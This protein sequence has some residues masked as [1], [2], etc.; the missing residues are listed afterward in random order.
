[1]KSL[2]SRLIGGLF[3][4]LGLAGLAVGATAYVIDRGAIDRSLDDELREIA[5][6]VDPFEAARVESGPATGEDIF[7]AVVWTGAGMV[8]PEGFARPTEIGLATVA[9]AGEDWRVYADIRADRTVIGAQRMEVRRE[10]VAA[11]A[12]QAV[13]PILL[14]IPVAWITIG[15]IVARAMRPLDR[16]AE[17]L[18]NLGGAAVSLSTAGVPAEV[19]PLVLAMNDLIARLQR[20][21][22]FR[23]QFVSDAAHE[24]RTPLAALQLQLDARHGDSATLRADAASSVAR[25]SALVNQMLDL[26]R[27]EAPA[28]TAKVRLRLDAAV[29]AVVGEILPIAES[30]GIDLGAI[31]GTAEEVVGDAA[32]LRLLLR[33]LIDNAIRYTPQGGRVDLVTTRVGEEIVF[34]V[35]DTGP[36]I[37]PTMLARVFD[38]FVRLDPNTSGTGLGLAIARAAAGRMGATLTV[39]NR[40]DGPGLVAEVRFRAAETDA[41]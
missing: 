23:T 13:L 18:P 8:G 15:I 19:L 4:I 38:R 20:Q 35:R 34:E 5:Q 37:P 30:R 22:E 17:E 14:V 27:I 28:G 26:A 21:I 7:V 36:G 33:N 2:R 12:F 31:E 32:D 40:S 10:L 29:R 41:R 39:R 11:R 24:L 6:N 1:M 25:M 9:A 3:L 16:L